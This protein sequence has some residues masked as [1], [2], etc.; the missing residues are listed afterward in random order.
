VPI[1]SGLLARNA[2]D[3][4]REATVDV[5]IRRSDSLPVAM[6]LAFAQEP[7]EQDPKR[8][9]LKL[10]AVLSRFDEPAP[11]EPPDP[12]D[13]VSAAPTPPPDPGE[14]PCRRLRRAVERAVPLKL[15]KDWDSGTGC[16]YL[17]AKQRPREAPPIGPAVH[18]QPEEADALLRA[19][20][21]EDG[22]DLRGVGYDAFLFGDTLFVAAGGRVWGVY[23][24]EFPADIERGPILRKVMRAILTRV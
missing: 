14:M 23:L 7:S 1:G 19:R 5:W 3:P 2:W 13:V 9:T 20:Y 11:I 18:V 10:D 8:L 21:W 17:F 22:R 12:G 24:V 4:E 6:R 15:G 16:T